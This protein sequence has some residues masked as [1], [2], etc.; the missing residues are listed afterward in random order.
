MAPLPPTP[1]PVLGLTLHWAR[2]GD[3]LAQTKHLFAFTGAPADGA[4]LANLAASVVTAAETAFAGVVD[5]VTGVSACTLRDLSVAEGQQGT[6]GTPWVGTRTGAQ[7]P[8]GSAVVVNHSVPRTYRGGKPKTFL[9]AGT[10]GDVA[11]TGFWDTTLVDAVATAWGA[12]T[13]AVDGLSHGTVAIGNIVNVS[14]FTGGSTVVISPTTGRARNVPK[15]RT[16]PLV[17]NFT[18]HTVSKVIGS[19]RRRNRDA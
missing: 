8:P 13:A 19:Q 10:G 4:D 18:A 15:R 5:T 9:P 11:S 2:A 7:L 1:S 14:Y 17:E 16:T 3:A 12:F 6:G